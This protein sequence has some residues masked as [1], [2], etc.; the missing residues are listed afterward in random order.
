MLVPDLFHV[1]VG[2]NEVGVSV[3]IGG[4]KG[5]SLRSYWFSEV[6]ESLPHF[7]KKAAEKLNCL[8]PEEALV[9]VAIHALMRMNCKNVELR[10]TVGPV[11]CAGARKPIVPMSI[12][13]EIVVGSIPKVQSREQAAMNAEGPIEIRCHWVRGHFA[14]YTKGNGLFGRIKGVF[15]IPEHERGSEELGRVIPEYMVR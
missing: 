14:D 3:P 9:E 4:V 2:L 10:P 6:Y 7:Q 13:H 8:L 1:G 12:W 11:L 5:A 15:W